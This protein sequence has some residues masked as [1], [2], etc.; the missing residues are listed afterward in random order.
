MINPQRAAERVLGT[1]QWENPVLGFCTCPGAAAHTTPT[2]RKDCR[3][4]LDEVPTVYC[5]H[6]HCAGALQNA[7]KRLRR[8]LWDA[9]KALPTFGE[10][11]AVAP[12]QS[13]SPPSEADAR[14]SSLNEHVRAL[15]PGLQKDQNW[16]LEEIIR[17]SPV[18]LTNVDPSEQFRLWLKLWPEDAVIWTGDTL[19]SGRPENADNFRTATEWAK[20]GLAIGNFTCASSFVPGGM[21]RADAAVAKRHFLVVESD[22]LNKDEVGAVFRFLTRRLKHR[23]HCIVDT[24]GKSLHGWF[25]APSVAEIPRLKL[26]LTVLGCDPKMFGKSQPCRV[27]GAL[28]GE[29]RQSLIWLRAL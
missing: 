6:T 22:T 28:R 23:L 12:N 24:G 5:F 26:A 20:R 4:S 8:S 7:N 11:S 3:V 13:A 19:D 18:S 10:A 2:G 27:P 15:I 1:V 17:S 25:S 14:D 21:R 9:S 16:P 29:N